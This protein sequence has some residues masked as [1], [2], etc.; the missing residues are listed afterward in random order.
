MAKNPV[1]NVQGAYM[2]VIFYKVKD[3][4]FIRKPPEKVRQSKR[5]KINSGWFGKAVALSKS[6]RFALQNLLPDPKDRRTMYRLNNVL[7][8]WLR[9]EPGLKQK[10]FQQ[11]PKLDDFSLNNEYEL[12]TVWKQPWKVNWEVAGKVTI[13][14]PPV[15][16]SEQ[17]G[18]PSGTKSISLHIAVIGCKLENGAVTEHEIA[19]TAIPYSDTQLGA[20]KIELPFTFESG[21][22]AVAAVSLQY[23]LKS[24]TPS[25]QRNPLRWKPAGIIDAV[26]YY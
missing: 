25:I 19:S 8:Q 17:I 11:I 9:T 24:E 16:P 14:I 1:I 22:V 4:Y 7:Y 5:T 21:V 3:K 6:L 2:G 20:V 26:Y 10:G 18:A 23:H 13:M 15:N 12:T